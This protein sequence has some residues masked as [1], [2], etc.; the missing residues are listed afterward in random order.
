MKTTSTL[1]AVKRE[2][3]GKG[4]A[5]KLRASGQVPVV[6]YGADMDSISLTVDAQEALHLF[7]AISVENTIVHLEVDGESEPFETLVRDIQT[8]PFRSEILHVDFLR[9]QKGVAVDVDI[10][11]HL[12]GVPLGVKQHGGN[13]EQV[14]YELPVRC[15]PSK[16]PETIQVDVSALDLNESIHVYDLEL[17]EGV[18]VTI[19]TDRTICNVSVPRAEEEPTTDEE[20]MEGLE[21]QEG[22][23]AADAGGEAASAD[24]GGGGEGE[25]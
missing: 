19:D 6:L 24:A 11:L 14:I 2:G 12:E 9:I 10:P 17:P 4:V 21:G 8:H 5:R 25:A 23:A 18:E 22:E 16:I 7:Q 15:I 3:T 1:S 20:D 13:L